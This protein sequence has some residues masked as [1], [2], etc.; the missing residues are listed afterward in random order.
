MYEKLNNKCVRDSRICVP[1][2][3]QLLDVCVVI[4]FSIQANARIVPEMTSCTH[5]LSNSLFTDHSTIQCYTVLATD[6]VDK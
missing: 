5:I 1:C 2:W 3:V 4:S 6:S